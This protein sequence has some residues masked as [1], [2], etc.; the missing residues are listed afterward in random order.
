MFEKAATIIRDGSV[1]DFAY[2]PKD[3]VHRELQMER[4]ETL[5]R[6][7]ALDGRQ[8]TAFLTGSVG[9]GKT[10][11]LAGSALIWRRSWPPRANPWMS[12]T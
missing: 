6:P 7:M 5:F 10:S 11:P 9:T 12:S 1:L 3:L 4:L 8:C 2:I